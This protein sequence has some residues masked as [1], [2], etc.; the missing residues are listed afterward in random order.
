MSVVIALV[1]GAEK[2]CRIIVELACR[3]KIS[4]WLPTMV[5]PPPY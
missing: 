3:S 1:K 5:H 4:V 2:R